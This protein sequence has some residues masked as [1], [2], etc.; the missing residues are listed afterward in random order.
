MDEHAR[1]Q[2]LT[3]VSNG[4]ILCW[5]CHKCF[6]A[7]LVCVD[8][9]SGKLC[10]ADALLSCESEKWQ[11]LV[12]RDVPTGTVLQLDRRRRF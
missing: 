12:D 2:R 5:G 9:N 8:S 10:V 11:K 6:G 1:R 4:I 7:N 3:K